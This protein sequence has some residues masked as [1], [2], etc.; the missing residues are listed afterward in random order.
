MTCWTGEHTPSPAP[1]Q[2]GQGHPPSGTARTETVTMKD[3]N[4]VIMKDQHTY[5]E[6]SRQLPSP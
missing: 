3:L 2:T 1:R 5:H 4:T 6:G